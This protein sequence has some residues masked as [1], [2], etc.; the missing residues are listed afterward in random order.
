M[1]LRKLSPA[2][3]ALC[4]LFVGP[5]SRGQLAPP[6]PMPMQAPA[7]A[8]AGPIVRSIEVQYAGASTISKEKILANMRT[9]VGRPYSEQIVEEDIRNLYNTGNISNV[10]IFG[11]PF[12]DDVARAFESFVFAC[13]S[14]CRVDKGLHE[15]RERRIR[16]LL[17]P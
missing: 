13:N 7:Q 11:D 12:G 6:P 17:V 9:R 16:R 14:L 3:V 4:V 1:N 15:S 8:P 10:R 5:V 2:V